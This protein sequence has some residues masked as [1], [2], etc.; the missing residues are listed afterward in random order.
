VKNIKQKIRLYLELM[1]FHRPTGFYLLGWPTLWALWLAAAGHPHIKMIVI[2]IIGIIVTRAA[3]CIVNDLADYKFDRHVERTRM[4]PLASGQLSKR[5]AIILFLI[6]ISI[7]LALVL[8]L[9]FYC[10]IVSIIAVL[11]T[12]FYPLCK[13]FFPVP[14]AIL[15]LIFNGVLFAF[16]AE[17]NQLPLLAWILYST[18]FLWTMAYDTQYAMTDQP[19]DELLGLKSSAIFF[20]KHVTLAILIFQLL[21]LLGLIL[22][23]WLAKLNQFYWLSLILVGSLISYQQ[24][25]L[26][27]PER[28]SGFNA[29]K[30]NNW[31]GL[32][33]FVG[34]FL[35]YL[36]PN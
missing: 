36:L 27:R 21:F 4:R 31:I 15:G 9:N 3:G 23:G 1:R 14:Q 34:I 32:T 25:L 8:Q 12:L 24:K 13:R 35:N 29:F 17:Q 6:L 5:E 19:D 26:R 28:N 33:I 22:T 11:L 20:G 7:A 30:S 18:A 10:L 16:A 2:F